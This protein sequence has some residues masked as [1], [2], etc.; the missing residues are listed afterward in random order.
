MGDM[1]WHS[2]TVDTEMLISCFIKIYQRACTQNTF[3]FAMPQVQARMTSITSA[4]PFHL[5]A[6]SIF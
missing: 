2:P 3:P 4:L 1:T 5:S 6:Y